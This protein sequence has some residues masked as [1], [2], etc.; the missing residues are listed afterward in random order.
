M[1]ITRLA[2]R[3]PRQEVRPKTRPLPKEHLRATKQRDRTPGRIEHRGVPDMRASP[4]M[5]GG[6]DGPD[7]SFAARPQEVA[8]EFECRE[9]GRLIGQVRNAGVTAACIG[10]ADD[11]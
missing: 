1:K 9:V 7:R 10:K 5:D 8:L 11:S 6:C 4:K 3:L 2:R